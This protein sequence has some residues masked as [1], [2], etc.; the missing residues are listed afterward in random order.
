M[1]TLLSQ[2]KRQAKVNADI[3]LIKSTTSLGPEI[4][5]GSLGK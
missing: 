5:R 2:R 4:N 1:E 3:P